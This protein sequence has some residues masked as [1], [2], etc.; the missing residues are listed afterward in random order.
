MPRLDCKCSTARSATSHTTLT[1]KPK[2][3]ASRLMPRRSANAC[4][5]ASS[6]RISPANGSCWN[7]SSTASSSPTKPWRS[8]TQSPLDQRASAR[9]FVYCEQ[10]IKNFFQVHG[11]DAAGQVVLRRK[12]SRGDVL[13]FF[14]G[15]PKVLVGIEACGTGHYWAREIAALGHEVKLLPPTYVKRGKTDAADAEAICE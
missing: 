8:V 2:P 12:L 10:T 6:T 3:L 13:Q 1:T 15:Q 9:R 5:R 4:G 14:K 11:V 7:C